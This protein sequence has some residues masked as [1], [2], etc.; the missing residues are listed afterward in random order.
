[1][2]SN[3]SETAQERSS[4]FFY[5]HPYKCISLAL[6]DDE[7]C[8]VSKYCQMFG[9]SVSLTMGLEIGRSVPYRNNHRVKVDVISVAT[10]DCN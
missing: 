10:K 8:T 1:M 4:L 5:Q 9:L 6:R 2:L 3:C 7:S